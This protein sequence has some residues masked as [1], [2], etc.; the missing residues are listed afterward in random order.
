LNIIKLFK[1]SKTYISSYGWFGF[2]KQY[3]F[4]KSIIYKNIFS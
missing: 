4:Y 1:L 2:I 3:T